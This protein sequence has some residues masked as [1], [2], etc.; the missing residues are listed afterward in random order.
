[1]VHRAE[2]PADRDFL[3]LPWI[4]GDIVVCNDK[5]EIV[6][7]DN[8]CPHRGARFFL[9]DTGNAPVLCPYHGW[10]YRGGRMRI[11]RPDTFQTCDLQAV[12][13]NTLT[14]AWCGDFLFAAIE[15]EMD[16]PTQL[17]A[18]FPLLE[19]ISRDVERRHA[20]DAYIYEC[21]WRVAVENAL[22]PDHVHM[23]H[24]RSLDTL[25]LTA[26]QDRFEG[27]N[28][29][30][31]AEIGNDRSRRG[32]H[33]MRRF[34]NIVHPHDGYLALYLFPFSFVS[35][36]FG[37]TYA[38]QNMLPAREP[39]RTRFTTRLLASRV[40][41]GAEPI[42]T[43]FLDSAASMNRQV[44]EEDHAICRRVD[45]DFPLDGPGQVLSATESRVRHFRDVMAQ[46]LRGL[47]ATVA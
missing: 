22:E 2:L 34:F 40:A 14:T 29:L 4:L 28:A 25:K 11:P 41:P 5:G 21:P 36:T 15:P 27:R 1:M 47:H 6:V 13:L 7:F 18:M 3:R 19:G 39:G 43:P 8:L 46:A 32:L 24:A 26:A 20:M 35:S 23:V 44:F 31:T 42:T 45:P 9:E 37:Y 33:A 30:F 38:V 12:R 10:N 17:G 16:L